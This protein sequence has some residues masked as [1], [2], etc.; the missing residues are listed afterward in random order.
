MSI[1]NKVSSPAIDPVSLKRVLAMDAL[2]SSRK[3]VTNNEW[4]FNMAKNLGTISIYSYLCISYEQIFEGILKEEKSATNVE[5]F[6][7][8]LNNVFLTCFTIINIH[9]PIFQIFND[10]ID[11]VISDD[12]ASYQLFSLRS[13]KNQFINVKLA[14]SISDY[15]CK[16]RI[17]IDWLDQLD[18]NCV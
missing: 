6:E 9:E 1:K 8:E 18:T 7:H 16:F 14:K 11:S 17:F 4:A 3:N 2:V 5:L 10:T 15:I 12:P 13:L